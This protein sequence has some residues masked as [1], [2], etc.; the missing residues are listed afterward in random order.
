MSELLRLHEVTA[1]YADTLTIGAGEAKNVDITLRAAAVMMT[2]MVVSAV[3]EAQAR[4]DASATIDV[5]TGTALR[6]A[7]AA[8][9]AGVAQRIPGV[10][11][12]QLSGE[13]HSTAIRQP[14]STKPRERVPNPSGQWPSRRSVS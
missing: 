1:G 13:G 11:V 3:R 12:S 9:P 6:E 4:A 5:V 2:P 7:R 8:H 14:I 10:H